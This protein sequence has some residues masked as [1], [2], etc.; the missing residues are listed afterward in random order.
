L[1]PL[2]DPPELLEANPAG[3]V[4]ALVTPELTL[5]DS[6]VICEYLDALSN[7]PTRRPEGYARWA[8][9]RREALGDAIMDAATSVVMEQ[10]RPQSEQS[11]AW[12]ERQLGKIRRMVACI[13]SNGADEPSLGDIAMACAL[14]YL[15]FRHPD[16]EWRGPN[17]QVAE[18]HRAI[19]KRGSFAGSP[20]G[21]AK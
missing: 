20:L 8:D 2:E 12:V 17:E 16:L 9:L 7:G 18:W 3:K 13:E 11:P 1:N 19:T 5:F 6:R 21:A 10:R 14:S 4:P 15:D